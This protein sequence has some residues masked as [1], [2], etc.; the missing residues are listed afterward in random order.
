MEYQ[1]IGREK[2][3]FNLKKLISL[4]IQK[5]IKFIPFVNY[6]ILF[7]WLF[8]Y[9]RIPSNLKLLFRALFTAF[10]YVFPFI[11]LNML[12]SRLFTQTETLL[13]IQSI[14]GLYIFPFQVDLGLIKCQEKYLS[15]YFNH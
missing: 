14:I 4:K 10:A 6:F 1:L 7:I 15:E 11:V 9:S 2:E 8:N 5:T 12:L 3:S 13:V